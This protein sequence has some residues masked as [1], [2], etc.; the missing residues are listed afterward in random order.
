MCLFLLF[1]PSVFGI[2]L[3]DLT[4]IEVLV[5]LADLIQ[6]Q[7]LNYFKTFIHM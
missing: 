5:N 3:A 2:Q 6:R 4:V 7:L 1:Q